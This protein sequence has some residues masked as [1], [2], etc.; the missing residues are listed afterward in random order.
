MGYAKEGPWE[1]DETITS[2]IEGV[3]A[4]TYIYL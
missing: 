1:V 2:A 4:E 3:T